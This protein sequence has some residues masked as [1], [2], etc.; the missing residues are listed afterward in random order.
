VLERHHHTEAGTRIRLRLPLVHDAPG[1]HALLERLGLSTGDLDARRALRW[2][3]RRRV[4]MCATAWDG[5]RESVVGFA[6][7][8]CG[9]D[10][11]TLLADEDLA[12]GVRKLLAAALDEHTRTWGRRVA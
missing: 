4:A 7:A 6:A 1:L 12:P 8:E 2:A 9:S 10:R 5:R 3:P 11:V